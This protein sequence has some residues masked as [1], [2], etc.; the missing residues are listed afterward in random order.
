[1][2][3]AE[4]VQLVHKQV[5]AGVAV[6][7]EEVVVLEAVTDYQV[8]ANLNVLHK[9]IWTF[10]LSVIGSEKQETGSKS[11]EAVFT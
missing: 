1:M 10:F 6:P 11:K 5:K 9:F 4:A 2:F 8:T 3:H 7:M